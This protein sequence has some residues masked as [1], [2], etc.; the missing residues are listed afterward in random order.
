MC[1]K[2]ADVV[3]ITVELGSPDQR[4]DHESVSYMPILEKKIVEKFG[5]KLVMSKKLG[6]TKE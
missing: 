2:F 6:G 1:K 3:M 4:G 5:E